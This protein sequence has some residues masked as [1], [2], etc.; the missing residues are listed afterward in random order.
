MLFIVG[1]VLYHGFPWNRINV[2]SEFGVII[3][4]QRVP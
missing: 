1:A 3:V 4:D 2:R